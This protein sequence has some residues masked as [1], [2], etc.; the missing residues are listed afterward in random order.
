MEWMEMDLNGM[1]WNGMNIWNG[2]GM[3]TGN[4]FEP[5]SPALIIGSRFGKE[6]FMTVE[7]EKFYNN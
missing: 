7:T 2:N 6:T 1:E 5:I 3:E 4:S